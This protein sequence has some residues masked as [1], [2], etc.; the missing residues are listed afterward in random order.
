MNFNFTKTLKRYRFVRKEFIYLYISGSQKVTCFTNQIA[1]INMGI[2]NRFKIREI[3]LKGFKSFSHNKGINITLSDI[4]VLLGANGSG[5]SNFISFIRMLCAMREG[6][7]Q[8]YLIMNDVEEL[9]HYGP[10]QT[11]KIET[12]FVLS[13]DMTDKFFNI[14]L[15]YSIKKL[16]VSR[17]VMKLCDKKGRIISIEENETLSD[18]SSLLIEHLNT[19]IRVFDFNDVRIANHLRTACSMRATG[20]LQSDSSN[21][22]VFLW[23]LKNTKTDYYS[24]I[25]SYIKEILPQFE[26]F[27]INPDS[28]GDF[29]LKWKDNTGSENKRS[30]NQLSD[31]SLRFAILACLLLQPKEDIPEIIVLDNPETGLHPVAVRQMA[32]MVKEASRYTQIIIATQSP[33]LLDELKPTQIIIVERDC[34]SASSIMKLLDEKALDIWLKSYTLSELW[35][36]NVLGGR[37]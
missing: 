27:C 35:E 9:F 11:Q 17:E 32:E 20:T 36:K 26:D 24:R 29:I 1:T 18:E 7:L 4:N 6:K 23:Y 21:F 2:E 25:I 31:S 13:D 33:L 5:K 10:K 30:L 22:T 34:D 37:P 3:G 16:L 12:S 28:S 8:D 19:N 15:T 14:E